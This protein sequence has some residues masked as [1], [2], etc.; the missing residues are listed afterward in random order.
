MTSGSMITDVA[1][2]ID[3]VMYPFTMAFKQY[4]QVRM[5]KFD[6]P[7]PTHWEFYEDWG[8][9]VDQFNEWLEDATISDKVFSWM[10][11]ISGTSTAWEM[12]R[13]QGIKI[14]VITH[15][16]P[17]AWEQTVQWLYK[18]DLIPDSLHFTMHKSLITHVASK[19][20]ALIDDNVDQ[21]LTAVDNG[22]HAFLYD[23]P[24][25][26]GIN[27]N[28]VINLH[29]FALR[30]L[31]HNSALTANTKEE[32]W[33]TK[34]PK[35][36]KKPSISSTENGTHRMETHLT[37]LEQLRLFGRPISPEQFRHEDDWL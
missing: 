21:Y 16:I 36:F 34:E 35:Y 17:L 4:C 28:R 12:L 30:V 5:Q 20:G 33:K 32:S 27:A 8:M 6:L 19:R 37:T 26:Q 25:N 22:I 2:D 23:Q 15:R 1:I 14:H 24:W 10:P 31:K 29:D 18:H 3:G 13:R 11:P 7:D 9:S